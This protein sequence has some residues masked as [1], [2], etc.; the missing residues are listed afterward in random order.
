MTTQATRRRLQREAAD[1]LR[2]GDVLRVVAWFEAHDGTL[3]GC[4]GLSPLDVECLEL[5]AE[6]TWPLAAFGRTGAT[7]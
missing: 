4:P 5:A 2:P 6:A 1:F 7:S 3:S